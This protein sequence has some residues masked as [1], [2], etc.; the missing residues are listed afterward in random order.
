MKTKLNNSFCICG[1][2]KS[3]HELNPFDEPF[4][5]GCADNV[6]FPFRDVHEVDLVQHEFKLDNLKYF[7]LKYQEKHDNLLRP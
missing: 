1:H 7:E 2:K 5:R 3:K 4:C 6:P